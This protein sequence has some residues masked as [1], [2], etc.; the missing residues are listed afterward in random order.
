[1]YRGT[2]SMIEKA[3]RAQA[4]GAVALLIVNS[5]NTAVRAMRTCG[6]P[7]VAAHA[8][9][10]RGHV[11][12]HSPRP[13]RCPCYR[14]APADDRPQ[15]IYIPVVMIGADS[16]ELLSSLPEDTEYAIAP[17]GAAGSAWDDLSGVTSLTAEDWPADVIHRRRW[18][19]ELIIANHPEAPE[20]RRLGAW[21]LGRLLGCLLMWHSRGGWRCPQGHWQRYNVV[22]EVVERAGF[23]EELQ[24]AYAAV[25][26]TLMDGPAEESTEG[27]HE[28][29]PRAAAGVPS[30]RRGLGYERCLTLPRPTSFLLWSRHSCIR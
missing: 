3:R 9:A 30:A 4:A 26:A 29:H 18:L 1:M 10:R 22:K 17:S 25:K 19:E 15:D 20:V 7:P 11:P 6:F 2:C 5:D 28:C 12:Q 13:T 27:A 8:T 23:T 21:E 14:V 24:Q 16:W